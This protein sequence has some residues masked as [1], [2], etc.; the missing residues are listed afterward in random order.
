MGEQTITA[1][2][3][4]PATRASSLI[5]DPVGMWFDEAAEPDVQPSSI[6]LAD[7]MSQTAKYHEYFVY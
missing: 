5:R 4:V 3:A 2:T 7:R 1:D 6:G